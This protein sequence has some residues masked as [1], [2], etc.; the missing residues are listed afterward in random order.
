MR[1]RLGPAAHVGPLGRGALAEDGPSA[2]RPVIQAV[3]R[4]QGLWAPTPGCQRAA[5]ALSPALLEHTCQHLVDSRR[6]SVLE[7]DTEGASAFS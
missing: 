5:S 6:G 3:C 1:T 2:Q 7:A 4:P